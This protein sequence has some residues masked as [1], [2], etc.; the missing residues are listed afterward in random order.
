MVAGQGG[1]E[2]STLESTLKLANWALAL[3]GLIN[4]TC[5]SHSGTAKVQEPVYVVVA[6]ATNI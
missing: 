2:G 1:A 4:V 3:I 6:C 5:V